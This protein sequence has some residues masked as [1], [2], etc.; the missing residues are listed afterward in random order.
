MDRENILTRVKQIC[1]EIT[2][3]EENEIKLRASFKDDLAIP[4]LEL[5][6][7]LA[8]VEHAFEIVLPKDS[9]RMIKRVQDLVE[10]IEEEM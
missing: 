4:P 3:V 10:V 2:G 9:I 5:A 6:E 7:V 8:K 1:S